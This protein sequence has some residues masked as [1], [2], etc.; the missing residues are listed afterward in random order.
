VK[1]DYCSLKQ[2][3]LFLH[4]RYAIR[5]DQGNKEKLELKG[6]IN[7]WSVL[8]GNTEAPT[9]ANREVGL[10]QNAQKTR[11]TSVSHNHDATQNYNITVVD[12]S[13]KKVAGVQI[14]GHDGNRSK[15][16]FN[17]KLRTF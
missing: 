2:Y 1:F 9:D 10:E 16:S 6:H 13:F 5:K 3:R 11:Y 14:S 8:M 17:K 15:L 12:K 4:C 7:I